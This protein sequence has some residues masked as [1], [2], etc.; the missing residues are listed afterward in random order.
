V[1]EPEAVH[2]MAG[3]WWLD[4]PGVELA[5]G[6]GVFLG[7]VGV[8]VVLSLWQ[9]SKPCAFRRSVQSVR[10]VDGGPGLFLCRTTGRGSRDGTDLGVHER[11]RG[12]AWRKHGLRPCR[13]P[14]L[15]GN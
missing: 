2:G 10:G 3:A 7:A 11:A 6:M 8:K 15:G 9:L 12:C 1:R 13:A 14:C 5:V 4:G